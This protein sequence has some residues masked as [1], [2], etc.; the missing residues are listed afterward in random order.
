MQLSYNWLKELLPDLA[1]SPEEVAQTL[2]AHSFETVVAG[3]IQI[4]PSVKVMRITK[5]EAHPNADRLQ[6][7]TITDDETEITV[8][9]GA[10]NIAVDQVVPY[11]PPGT[12]V[13]DSEGGE[14][15][16]KEAT[17]RGTKSPGMLNS[18]RELGLHATDHGGIWILPPDLPLGSAL[19]DHFPDDTILEA[20]ITPNRAHDCLGHMGVARELASILQLQ[21]P[22]VLGAD[23]LEQPGDISV[24]ISNEVDTPR[25]IAAHLTGAKQAISPMWLQ[26][27]LLAAGG[28][29]KN[30]LVDI[31][32]YV[33]FEIGNPT[34]VFDA[35][36]LPGKEIVVRRAKKGEKITALDEVVYEPTED[37]LLITAGDTPIAI[38]GVMGG[39]DSAVGDATTDLVLE[40]ASFGSYL[41]QETSRR[42][43]LRSESSIRFGKGLHL[44]IAGEAARRIIYLLQD[45]A[46]AQ[47][48]SIVDT[49]PGPTDPHVILFRPQLPSQVA[50]ITIESEEVAD[51]LRQLRCMVD[52][53][54][55]IWEV[56]V[57]YERLDLEGEHDLVEEV[58]RMYGLEKI[59]ARTD[60]V[61]QPLPIPGHIYLRNRLRDD[62]VALGMTETYNYSYEPQVYADMLGL[63]D[64]SH[65]S[66]SNPPAP[67]LA[68]LRVS[69]LPGLLANAVTNRDIFQK[70]A[71]RKESSLFEI[72]D[73][74]I[75]GNGTRVP[76]VDEY[77]HLAA[78]VIGPVPTREQIIETIADAYGVEREVVHSVEVIPPADA[79]NVRA[80]KYRVPV[81]L[82]EFNLSALLQH[83]GE[84][85]GA[86]SALSDLSTQ[87]SA[88]QFVPY[89][90]YPSV[91]RDISMLV[92]P[93]V[94]P[95]IAQGVIER[96]GKKLI[97]DVDLFDELEWKDTGK[98][99]LAFHV[100]YQADDRTLT[101][102]EVTKIHQEITV[103]LTEELEAEIR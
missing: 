97:A 36:K 81:M 41:V 39:L 78:I 100:E 80:L 52:D 31:T 4:D 60:V 28:K 46:H 63:T 73:V 10:P 77:T 8:V 76:G 30:N 21:Q 62:L 91:I 6:L 83:A 88:V 72:G 24:V 34:H 50:G 59:P 48:V 7:A 26:V 49:N 32:N 3:K 87:S 70:N 86:T 96:V 11:S 45:V 67:E 103:A 38:A 51:I 99:S 68:R 25:Y 14:F 98:K 29:P 17:I 57:P 37:D 35:E 1:L 44:Q 55:D 20:D 89:S 85:M 64:A 47:L 90:K 43:H 16:V 12:K 101:D 54:K 61:M 33:L 27:R 13:I 2:T 79:A 18:L 92:S 22:E 58:I 23:I 93:S 15:V 56:S 19:V 9:C 40:V 42:L 5:V 94:T 69:L 66:L 65:L 95:E 102:E 71:G 84:Q 53:T 82:Y 74:Y 75:A